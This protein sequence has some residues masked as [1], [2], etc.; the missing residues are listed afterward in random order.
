[1]YHLPEHLVKYG[2]EV[3]VNAIDY[4]NKDCK[5]LT[6]EGVHFQ[7]TPATLPSVLALP[8]SLYRHCLKVKPDIIFA[9]GDSHIG[10]MALLIAKKLHVPL[11]FDVYDYYPIF[12]GNRIPGMKSFFR[13]TVK[14]ADL[15]LC[16][17]KPLLKRL[18]CLNENQLLVENGVDTSF[19]SPVE[20]SQARKSLR[21]EQDGVFVGYFG[22]I[23][24]ARGPLLIEA[25]RLLRQEF[26]A[27]RLIMAGRVT[28]VDL[29]EPWISYYGEIPQ[30]E[31]PTLINAC[32]LVTIPYADTPFNSMCGACKI[33]EYLACGKPVVATKVSDHARLFADAPSSLCDS[34][35]ESMV[36]ALRRQLVRRERAVFPQHLAW[37]A[38]GSKLRGSLRSLLGV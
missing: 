38:I 2:A 21:L 7:T 9:S 25:C 31:I 3:W 19:F 20:M 30:S 16:A 15:V 22:S 12:K 13:H 28:G 37:D 17:S 14:K 27:L 4:R 24:A 23:N 18:A 33:A 6:M 8:Y 34:T 35:V 1:M 10:F 26:P 32:D 5:K 11:V 36:E 29:K